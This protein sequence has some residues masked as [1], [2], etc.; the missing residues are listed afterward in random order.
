MKANLRATKWSTKWKS[1]K[2]ATEEEAIRAA[3][4]LIDKHVEHFENRFSLPIGE[5][6]S[7]LPKLHPEPTF[8]EIEE[9]AGEV[10]SDRELRLE[11]MD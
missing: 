6:F 9:A 3:R 10:P 1:K 11:N 5:K 8:W 4:E 2:G 7:L